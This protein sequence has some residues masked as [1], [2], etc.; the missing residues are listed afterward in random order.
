VTIP[1]KNVIPVKVITE[2]EQYSGTVAWDNTLIEDRFKPGTI[3]T[4]TITLQAKTGYTFDGLKKDSFTVIGASTTNNSVNSGIV[5]AIFPST[6]SATS[7]DLIIGKWRINGD[8]ENYYILEIKLDG[9]GSSKEYNGSDILLSTDPFTYTGLTDSK[10]TIIEWENAEIDY[11][12]VDN[13]LTLDDSE[14]TKVN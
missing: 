14:Y 3:Y 13:K 10:I 2:N 12:I 11:T 9:T 6:A 5:T 1:V 8:E 7:A 4:A